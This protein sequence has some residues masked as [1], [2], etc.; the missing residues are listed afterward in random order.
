[1]VHSFRPFLECPFKSTTTQRR[2]RLQHG[3]Y[4]GVSR[5]SAQ[6]TVGKGLAQGPYVVARAGVVPTTLRLKVIDSTNAPSTSHA[7]VGI[8]CTVAVRHSQGPP[9]PGF[10]T[11]R[12]RHSQGSPLPG[13]PLAGFATPRVHHSQGPPLP[14]P[15]LYSVS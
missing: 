9:L 1:M 14:G 2:S 13:P 15:S 4:I 3:Y 10:T 6:A 12:V 7:T 5:R 11:P 8:L